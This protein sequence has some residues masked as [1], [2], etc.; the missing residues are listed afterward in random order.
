ML[1]ND[2]YGF[3]IGPVAKASYW[4]ST[5]NGHIVSHQDSVYHGGGEVIYQ[6]FRASSSTIL[7]GLI[8]EGTALHSIGQANFVDLTYGW[9]ATEWSINGSAAFH[10]HY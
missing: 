2:R 1:S 8:L 3:A 4:L 6:P 10:F 5:G 7:N 9:K